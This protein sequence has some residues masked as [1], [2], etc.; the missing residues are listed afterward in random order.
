MKDHSY[1]LWTSKSMINK[2]LSTK[3]LG[4]VLM[5]GHFWIVLRYKVST[6][7]NMIQL[8]N[9]FFAIHSHEQIYILNDFP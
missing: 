2:F 5:L 8:Q 1:N 4:T 6:F 3:N 9:I 7:E